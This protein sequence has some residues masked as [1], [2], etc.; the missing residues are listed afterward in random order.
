M[1][2]RIVY[3]R[4]RPE[5][6]K[7][8]E[9]YYYT[10]EISRNSTTK[11]GQ[12]PEGK[13]EVVV[14]YDGYK[15]FTRHAGNDVELQLGEDPLPD[16]VDAQIGHLL[17]ADYGRTDLGQSLDLDDRWG[18]VPL[19]VP[20]VS[21]EI[22]RAEQLHEDRHSCKITYEYVPTQ[23]EV[24]ALGLIIETSDDII[25]EMSDEKDA[26]LSDRD[27]INK[28][29]GQLNQRRPLHLLIQARLTISDKC[30]PAD[31]KYPTIKR[32]GLNW[33]TITSVHALKLH[34]EDLDPKPADTLIYNPEQGRLE[35]TNIPLKSEAEEKAAESNLR[36]YRSPLMRLQ[37]EQPGEL[38]K[39][40]KLT[41]LVELEIPGSLLSGLKVH[42]ADANGRVLMKPQEIPGTQAASD[43]T[44][45]ASQ[46]QAKPQPDTQAAS[47]GV[48]STV[49]AQAKPQPDTQAASDGAGGASQAQAKPLLDIQAASDGAGGA[50]QAQ[51]KPLLELST[52]I[53]SDFR[54]LLDDIFMLC[55]QALYQRLHF[56][57]II[58]EV[59]RI[60]DIRA[61][62]IDRGFQ[63]TDEHSLGD[64]DN[65]NDLQHL[66]SA[67]CTEGPVELWLGVYIWGKRYQAERE[68]QVPG[69][70]T[71]ISTFE[72][73]EIEI[74]MRGAMEGNSR[75]L[76]QQMNAVQQ[77]LRDRFAYLRA[78]R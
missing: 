29:F 6:I 9:R 71:F 41:G 33:P 24:I 74:Y 18:S 53:T 38:Y 3:A 46:A 78:R 44:G 19:C 72:S 59:L 8:T 5:K 36:T 12:E 56:D 31:G 4:A 37:I 61:A 39:Q 70:M 54:L 51:A 27:R 23:P 10:Q 68:A 20:V 73:G 62:L 22:D 50:S 34:V 11:S 60:A 77:A 15:Y 13:I 17:L 57:D 30:V 67:K 42:V 35:W 21:S 75:R 47:D 32:I 55:P 48:G 52:V 40:N 49:Q 76:T 28:R 63:I 26:H 58:P 14:P 45:G 2:E 66:M 43:S 25:N 1:T 16:H 7:F 69:G 64:N 65:D